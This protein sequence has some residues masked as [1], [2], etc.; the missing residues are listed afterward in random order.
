MESKVG[1][2]MGSCSSLG[3]DV[4]CRRTTG[5]S[6]ISCEMKSNGCEI[7]AESDVPDVYRGCSVALLTQHGK[8]SVIAPVLDA[9]LACRVRLVT[10]FDTDLLGTFT[11]DVAR[12]GT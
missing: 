8:E 9:A 1:V 3:G 11:R 12:A 6:D 2:L 7:P 10:G 5:N 4:P